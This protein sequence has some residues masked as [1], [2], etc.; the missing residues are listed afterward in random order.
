MEPFSPAEAFCPAHITGLFVIEDQPDS[1]LDQGSRGA[2]FCLSRGTASRIEPSGE[3]RD[4]FYLNGEAR[5]DLR[6]S[7]WILDEYRRKIDGASG[8][9]EKLSAGMR[10]EHTVNVPEG[11]GFGTSG[12]GA[13]SL[14]L[15]LE[16]VLGGSGKASRLR[17]AQAAH[18]A[19]VVHRTGLGTV[20]GQ[21][22]GGLELRLSPGAPGIGDIRSLPLPEQGRALFAVKGPA[23]TSSRLSDPAVRRRIN[24]WGA[25]LLEQ[26]QT[27]PSPDN[28]MEFSR[29]FA[30]KTGLIS[31]SLRAVLELWDRWG[32]TGSQLMFGEGL[33]SLLPSPPEPRRMEALMEESR[34]LGE[35]T[36]FLSHLDNQGGRLL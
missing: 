7:Q 23:S 4:T 13:V 1:L 24:R 6:V 25:S 11:S 5:D 14:A 35:I 30:E 3:D 21:E 2:G 22:T 34:A 33:F 28:L 16:G 27:A 9:P 36:C 17:A 31:P 15:A 20:A 12:A 8:T 18:R 29:R 32:I 26:L 19:E 10:I